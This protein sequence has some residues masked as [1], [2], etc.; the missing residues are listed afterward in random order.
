MEWKDLVKERIKLLYDLAYIDLKEPKAWWDQNALSVLTTSETTE[1]KRILDYV[2]IKHLALEQIEWACIKIAALEVIKKECLD[3]FVRSHSTALPQIDEFKASARIVVIG[4]VGRFETTKDGDVDISVIADIDP[5]KAKFYVIPLLED[6]AKPLVDKANEVL[7]DYAES[8]GRLM[9]TK[10]T[11]ED[12]RLVCLNPLLT[13]SEI[14]F[15]DSRNNLFA[16]CFCLNSG[17]ISDLQIKP[18][19]IHSMVMFQRKIRFDEF[20]RKLDTFTET[21]GKR[22]EQDA[23]SYEYKI[24][25]S[26]LLSLVALLGIEPDKWKMCYFRLAELLKAKQLVNRDCWKVIQMAVLHC[27]EYRSTPN[28]VK[29]WRAIAE[30]LDWLRR[31]KNSTIRLL[32]G[33]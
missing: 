17:D 25:V 33:V 15:E 3:E 11:Q 20:A 21:K 16:G 26:G 4:S 18:P 7:G 24:V 10:I 5:A 13:S 6:F 30:H 23:L 22:P 31:F 28:Q 2:D 8:K 14:F 29:N 19:E 1:A 27:I 32:R 9:F 12:L